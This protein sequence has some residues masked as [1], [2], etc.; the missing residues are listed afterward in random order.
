MWLIHLNARGMAW[1]HIHSLYADKQ[2][3]YRDGFQ[4]FCNI[5][6]TQLGLL[7]WAKYVKSQ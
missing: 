7:F 4:A 6:A 1:R 3:F 2:R 5:D